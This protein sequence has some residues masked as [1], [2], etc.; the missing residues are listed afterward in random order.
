M[1]GG[2]SDVSVRGASG[3]KDRLEWELKIRVVRLRCWG[4]AELKVET[5]RWGKVLQE[6]YVGGGLQQGME[7]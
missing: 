1:G 6:Q 5:K 2:G 7:C 3:C 4:G